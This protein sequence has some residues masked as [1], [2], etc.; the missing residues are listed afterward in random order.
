MKLG[1]FSYVFVAVASNQR[2]SWQLLDNKLPLLFVDIVLQIS[3]EILL[4]N[5]DTA[6]VIE[7]IFKTAK[8]LIAI[9]FPLLLNDALVA[10][11]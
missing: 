8:S 11:V 9:E 1:D 3:V 4:I 6:I 7:T 2:L 5:A 10:F